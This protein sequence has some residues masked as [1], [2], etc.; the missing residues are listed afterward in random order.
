MEE[1]QPR[2]IEIL[3]E[4]FTKAAKEERSVG[5]ANLLS[6]ILSQLSWL[7][8]MVNST[9]LV[10]T[11][12]N[13]LASSPIEVQREIVSQLPGLVADNEQI[14]VAFSLCDLLNETPSL[15]AVILDALGDM[16][17][18]SIEAAEL[19]GKVVK[20]LATV[21]M[22]TIPVLLTFVL[23]RLNSDE[24][25]P[26]VSEIRLNLDKSLKNARPHLSQRSNTTND[27]I[28]LSVEAL[29][30]SLMR[31]RSLADFW[32]KGMTSAVPSHA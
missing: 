5:D 26:I 19:R 16:N 14:R 32:F 29:Q 15:T 13:V 10:D 2:I 25:A 28:S 1:F 6:L 12:M 9:H 3:L 21:P 20:R 27:C 11:L 23:K 4:K 31:S 17:V 30:N 7:N 24:I 18:P 22:E 8:L